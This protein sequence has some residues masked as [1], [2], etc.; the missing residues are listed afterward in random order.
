MPGATLS[1]PRLAALLG[2]DLSEAE[3]KEALF[4]SKAEFGSLK[5][6]ELAVEVTPDRLDLL[7][8]GG[9]A[10]ELAGA[11]GLAEGLGYVP[12]P[13]PL[14]GL[15]AKA[16][17]SVKDL[18]PH[19]VC[20]AV[21]APADRPLDAGLF[22]EL[23]RFQETLHATVGRD[24]KSASLGLYP[25][26]RLRPPIHYA[27]EPLGQIRFR[28][29]AGAAEM[30]GEEFYKGHS[31]AAKYGALGRTGDMALTLRDDAGQVLSLPPVLNAA[32][33]GEI[34]VG[35]RRILIEST[36]TRAARAHEMVGYMLLPF[37]ARGWTVHPVPVHVQGSVDKGETAIGLR[38]LPISASTVSQQLGSRL[39]V[40]EVEAAL[41]KARL[42]AER[43]GGTCLVKVPPWRPDILSPVDLVEDVAVVRGLDSFAPILPPATGAG[44]RRPESHRRDALIELLIGLG[45]QEMHTVL[46][47]SQSGVERFSRPGEALALQNPVSLEFSHVRPVL[48]ATL[49]EALSRNTRRR[50]PQRVFEIGPVLLRAPDQDSG[51]RTDLRLAIALAGPGVGIAEVA[52]VVDYLVGRLGIQAGREPTDAPG[53][54]PGRTA[55]LRWAGETLAWM[56]EVAPEV[57]VDL[58]IPEPV[59]W[60]EVDL[61]RWEQLRGSPPPAPKS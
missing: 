36:G 28:P 29:L 47:L 9:L 41:S 15:E 19:L 22:E 37:V 43:E 12:A 45:Y 52:A 2:R 50:Y 53:S 8:E 16:N 59:A 58:K 49:I 18:R 14:P 10:G 35:D 33:V 34:A 6:G 30:S 61:A 24:R 57:L 25:I 55:R 21:V 56:G 54:V 13:A 48:R 39:S 32:G 4:R 1:A 17:P 51:T 27:L 42:G 26:E 38:T 60:A 44:R 46:L 7:D 5:G 11:L 31:M 20:A 40:A 3:L 23:V